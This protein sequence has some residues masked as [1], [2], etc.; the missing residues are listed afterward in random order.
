MISKF[1]HKLINQFI[2]YNSAGDKTNIDPRFMIRGSKN[3]Y[4]KQSG[5]IASRFGLERRG[6]ADTTTEGVKADFVW[7]SSIGE[8]RPLRVANS[9]LQVESDIV[10]SGTYVWYDLASSLTNTRFVF[11]TW[12]DNTAKRD[13]LL[14]VKGDSNLYKWSGGMGL[15]ASTTS[16][17]IVFSTNAASL[18][19]D[20]SGSVTIN[21][22][23]YTYSG[24]TTTTLT[25]VSGDPTGEAD[26]SVV[27]AVPV[28]N[29]TTPASGF[30]NDF[31]KT[32]NNQVHVGS[33]TSRLVYISSSTDYTD[34]TVPSPRLYG[35]PEVLTLDNLARGIGVVNG[36]AMISAGSS[37]WYNISYKDITV[38]ASGNTI[39]TEVAKFE[40]PGNESALGHEYIANAGNSIVYL[41][42]DKQLKRIGTFTNLVDPTF[43]S[44]SLQIKDELKNQTFTPVQGTTS[45]GR[46][47]SVGERIYLTS[48]SGGTT[49]IHETRESLDDTGQVVAERFWQP[50]MIWGIIGVS[51]IAGVEYGHSI[52]NPQ[53]YKLWDTDQWSDDSPDDEDLPYDCVL[54]MAYRNHGDREL[55]IK[56]NQSFYEG[57]L[58]EGVELNSKVYI[59]YQGAE[60]LQESYI[61][62]PAVDDND[63]GNPA[64][65]YTGFESPGLGDSSLGD[66][67]LGEG[68]RETEL[69][70][71]QL[72]KFKCIVDA[73]EVNCFEYSLEVSSEALDSRWE[74]IA[75]GT[76]AMPSDQDPTF[77]RN[78]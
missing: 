24:V 27:V 15:I 11:D 23:T 59:D 35:S 61:N 21:G 65:F 75:L 60:S 37:D 43:A 12:W 40:A 67:P 64:T 52:A 68:L 13:I 29:A 50:P 38:D 2:G 7:E 19:F 16:N 45:D 33:Y 49:Y 72:P 44:L 66:N 10:T 74:I 53:I 77:I 28:T 9:K 70:Q 14:Y 5:A 20:T 25:G 41:T 55:M 17:T 69:S 32:I 31:I 34:Y 56:L 6:S 62:R 47:D 51:L 42:R 22:T 71:E 58:P 73:T 26:G 4:K 8:D 63:T 1:N 48:A 3:V 76:N 57:Y 18:G 39:Q 54:R 78:N 30:N 36:N 46:V